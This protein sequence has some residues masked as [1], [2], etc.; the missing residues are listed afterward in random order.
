VVH[1]DVRLWV[2]VDPAIPANLNS[3]SATYSGIYPV[4]LYQYEAQSH[5]W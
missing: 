3:L 4:S 2:R 5:A 1:T